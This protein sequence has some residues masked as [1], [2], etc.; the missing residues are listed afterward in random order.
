MDAVRGVEAEEARREMLDETL[1]DVMTAQ[2]KKQEESSRGAIEPAVHV[3]PIE[4]APKDIFH[5]AGYG[6]LPVLQRLL[7]DGVHVN[8][9]DAQ[10]ATT[11]HWA[12]LNDRLQVCSF[13]LNHGAS[14]DA[15]ALGTTGNT[16]LHWATINGHFRV[17]HFL[18]EHGADVNKPDSKGY[19]ALFHAVQSGH[20]NIAEYL[21]LR[22]ADVHHIDK[23]GHTILHWAAYMG[24]ED[25]IELALQFDREFLHVQDAQGMTAL[26]WT[27]C[28]DNASASRFLIRNGANP[29]IK[30][31]KGQTPAQVAEE[32]NYEGLAEGL[33]QYAQSYR[34][35]RH[36][37]P[38]FFPDVYRS[39]FHVNIF[40]G[41][42]LMDILTYASTL[43]YY[44]ASYTFTTWTFI[45]AFALLVYLLS[46]CVWGDPG[47]ITASE[48]NQKELLMQWQM[49][50]LCLTC[51]VPR[52]PRSKH[53]RQCGICVNRMDHHC[54]WVNNCIGSK[55]HTVFM[56]MC[57]VFEV[58]ASLYIALAFIFL[59]I[60]PGALPLFPILPFLMHCIVVHPMVLF[61]A[62]WTLL[63]DTMVFFLLV[64]QAK[65]ISMNMTT[66]ELS[67]A[68]RYSHFMD[69]NGAFRNPFDKGF[70][71]NWKEFLSAPSES[72]T[73]AW[74]G[75]SNIDAEAIRRQ[76]TE[77]MNVLRQ[78]V[79][80][81]ATQ[82]NLTATAQEEMLATLQ[83]NMLSQHQALLQSGLLTNMHGGRLGGNPLMVGLP[84]GVSQRVGLSPQH[85]H[86]PHCQHN[87]GV[88]PEQAPSVA[89]VRGDNDGEVHLNHTIDIHNIDDYVAGSRKDK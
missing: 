17:V 2:A 9:R 10:G 48:A 56:L 38:I 40:W 75:I 41:S 18:V 77:I 82:E 42:L 39:S 44:T 54:A 47:K 80:Q 25:L 78:A 15:P 59:T 62:V 83:T 7:T 37:R 16:P 55:N 46:K 36:L 84:Q 51:T 23:E 35:K 87:H 1:E 33:R 28:R 70:V 12:A 79:S 66:N 4:E 71:E 57:G 29:L 14:I 49:G 11:L 72:C 60:E 85:V 24:H 31:M 20:K 3:E 74:P 30:E 65:Q 86:G 58:A 32:K 8:D 61:S 89:P 76:Q 6:D 68:H 19:T 5:A 73:A 27:A 45:M 81:R 52:P 22:E 34:W 64:T 26:H 67:N 63:F 50:A 13:L 21:L 53:C 43:V 88:V 69:A